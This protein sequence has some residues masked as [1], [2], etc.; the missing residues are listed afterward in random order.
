MLGFIFLLLSTGTTLTWNYPGATCLLMRL[1]ALTNVAV[2]TVTADQEGQFRHGV[3][4][5]PAHAFMFEEPGIEMNTLSVLRNHT[6]FLK[7]NL[8]ET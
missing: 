3:D 5:L 4:S 1:D 6:K 8:I 7:K 2:P